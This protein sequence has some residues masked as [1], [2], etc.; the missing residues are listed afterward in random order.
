MSGPQDWTETEQFQASLELRS[1][2]ALRYLATD[3]VGYLIFLFKA[4]EC[5]LCHVTFSDQSALAAHNHATHRL[6]S[7]HPEH[8]DARFECHVCGRKFTEKS[9][10]VIHLKTVHAPDGER[11]RYQCEICGI[12]FTLKGNLKK[13]MSNFHAAGVINKGR[14]EYA[15]SVLLYT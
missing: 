9:N 3:G 8:P 2:G 5:R 13:H 4:N 10:V 15:G 1:Y 14:G 7:T 12:K 11:R 6:R